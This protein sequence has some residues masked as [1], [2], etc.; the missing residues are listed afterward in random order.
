VF[1][2][3]YVFASLGVGFKDG[4]KNR[5]AINEIALPDDSEAVFKSDDSDDHKETT[6]D[7]MLADLEAL[8]EEINEI[9]MVPDE[10]E[11][12]EE[13]EAVVEA[14][15]EPEKQAG[16]SV[17]ADIDELLNKLDEL[18]IVSEEEKPEEE[19]IP[20]GFSISANID[21][22]MV[23]DFVTD[24]EEIP[25]QIVEE[26]PVDETGEAKTESTEEIP[27]AEVEEVA[28]E[29]IVE[30][31]GEDVEEKTEITV[32]EKTEPK[33]RKLFGKTEGKEQMSDEFVP[34]S[35]AELKNRQNK[36]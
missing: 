16:F 17:S 13:P 34:I 15:E 36:E 8:V 21:V 6:Y 18:S 29:T 27:Q 20:S 2:L 19:K 26:S 9:E 23:E 33:K 35:L 22:N 14:P 3:A 10:P 1:V 30:A 12:I 11:E 31:S 7:K 28:E 24:D 4:L 32:E 25:A 5:R